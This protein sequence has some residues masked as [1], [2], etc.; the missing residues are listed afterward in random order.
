MHE[1]SSLVILLGKITQMNPREG[2]SRSRA[3][4][5]VLKRRL[6][7]RWER[8][9]VCNFLHVLQAYDSSVFEGIPRV[10][11]LSRVETLEYKMAGKWA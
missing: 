5:I 11:P 1:K 8:L 9:E 10:A 2:S 7:N 3:L 4:K 6:C